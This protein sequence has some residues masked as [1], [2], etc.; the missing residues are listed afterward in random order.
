M[1][2]CC[3]WGRR[4]CTSWHR[5]STPTP[6]IG[7]FRPS[8][9]P[10][11]LR[12]ALIRPIAPPRI[13]FRPGGRGTEPTS[14]MTRK[15]F[16]ASGRWWEMCITW[17]IISDVFFSTKWFCS[18]IDRGSG[19][20]KPKMPDCTSAKWARS[21]KFQ[22]ST[23]STLSVSERRPLSEIVRAWR[24]PLRNKS[25]VFNYEGD[26]AAVELSWAGCRFGSPPLTDDTC[27]FQVGATARDGYI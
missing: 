18:H 10:S 15:A 9:R 5:R 12:L 19:R 1:C 25:T 26:S 23:A 14:G 17:H 16:G 4:I 20:R 13:A 22:R 11:D 7:G 8:T 3:G 27:V 2:R 21:L 24:Q 6:T